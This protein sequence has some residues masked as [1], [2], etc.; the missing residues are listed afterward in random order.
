MLRA[1]AIV[2]AFLMLATPSR[3]ADPDGTGAEQSVL[4]FHQA[5]EDG[6]RA[7][8]MDLLLPDVAIF[9]SGEV[10]LSRDA[11]AAEH[12]GADI[13]FVAATREEIVG[14][15]VHEVGD[16]AWATTRSR[17]TGTF[18]GKPVDV[19]GT[20]TMVLRRDGGGWRIAHIHWSSHRRATP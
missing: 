1:A 14:R 3:G 17:T 2:G 18:R 10:E 8:A 15:E 11:Y 4:A 16:T 19:D 13:E 7:K 12:L 9:E 20:E 5:L 6:D